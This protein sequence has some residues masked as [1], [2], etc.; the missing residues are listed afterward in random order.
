MIYALELGESH[1]L[2]A[3]G[4]YAHK[5]KIIPIKIR[6]IKNKK[7]RCC[8][9]VNFELTSATKIKYADVIAAKIIA[10]KKM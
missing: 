7:L 10:K 4:E 9:K 3:V 2:S 8:F 5:R 6:L 1:N